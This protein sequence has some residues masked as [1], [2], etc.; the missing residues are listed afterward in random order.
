MKHS[1]RPN[2]VDQADY[3]L[4]LQF[5]E[6]NFQKPTIGAKALMKVIEDSTPDFYS[7]LHNSIAGGGFYFI[8]HDVGE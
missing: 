5:K 7:P 4:P 2:T 3:T 6:I 8:S 1:F